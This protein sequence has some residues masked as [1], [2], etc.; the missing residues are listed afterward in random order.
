MAELMETPVML[1]VT[2]VAARWI[3]HPH[4]V[5]TATP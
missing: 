4:S 5:G 1:V 2:L 3:R